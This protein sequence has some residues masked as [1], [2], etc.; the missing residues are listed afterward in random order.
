[1]DILLTVCVFFVRLFV[2]LRIYPS[3]INLKAL[4]CAQRFIGVQGRESPILGTFA[5]P[6]VQ[7]RTNRPPRGS[8]ALVC[9]LADSS[10]T[11]ATRRIGMCG[12]AAVPDDGRTYTCFACMVGIYFCQ[13]LRNVN[14][15]CAAALVPAFVFSSDLGL[16]NFGDLC[17]D[18]GQNL[19]INVHN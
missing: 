9:A 10:C 2:R 8:R 18:G 3:K 11:L 17:M 14:A 6:E 15:F 5:P 13:N 19:F 7:N 1:M 16:R 12:Y 4:N